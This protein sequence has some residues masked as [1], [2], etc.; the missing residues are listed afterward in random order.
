MDCMKIHTPDG[1]ADGAWT[2]ERYAEGRD[3]R[4]L[5]L[6]DRLCFGG[7][8]WSAQAWWEAVL[9]PLFTV[10]IFENNQCL[11]GVTVVRLCPPP[12][13]LASLAVHPEWRGRGIGSRLLE[14]VIARAR[15]ATGWLCLEVDCD[16]RL[17]ARMYQRH[18]FVVARRF[19][20]DGRWRLEMTRRLSSARRRRAGAL[21]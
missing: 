16:N 6:F 21:L 17:A 11:I 10:T 1:I 7:R 4:T 14:H 2:A 5:V 20:E 8:A 12:A 3:A 15:R 19:W 9:D 13:D 18:G